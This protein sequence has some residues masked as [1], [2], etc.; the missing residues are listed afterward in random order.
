MTRHTLYYI[1]KKRTKIKSKGKTALFKA[2]LKKSANYKDSKRIHQRHHA[3]GSVVIVSC[4]LV[5]CKLCSLV[6]PLESLNWSVGNGHEV[7]GAL[8]SFLLL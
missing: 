6:V 3:T 8:V 1:D 5:Y 2:R 4:N 7:L